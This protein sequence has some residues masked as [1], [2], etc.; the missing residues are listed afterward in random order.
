MPSLMPGSQNDSLARGFKSLPANNY[1]IQE[2]KFQRK[3]TPGN[4]EE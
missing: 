4:E 1:L 3:T 2:Q